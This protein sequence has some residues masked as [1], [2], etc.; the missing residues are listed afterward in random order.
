MNLTTLQDN[1]ELTTPNSNIKNS[2]IL[3]LER[4]NTI[5]FDLTNMILDIESEFTRISITDIQKAIRN[6]S[7]G[8]YG[9]TYKFSTQ[10][11]CMWIRQYLKEK[12][13]KNIIF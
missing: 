7:L 4:T 6:G 1:S 12:N 8:K 9:A 5:P 10:V 3:A 11:V 2:L 13:A